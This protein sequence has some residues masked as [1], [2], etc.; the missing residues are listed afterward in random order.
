MFWK[1]FG[2]GVAGNVAGILVMMFVISVMLG[3]ELNPK[4][5][6]GMVILISCIATLFGIGIMW[7]INSYFKVFLLFALAV[8]VWYSFFSYWLC[9]FFLPTFDL[10]Q[11]DERWQNVNS[12]QRFGI[13]IVITGL[14]AG[15]Y[16]KI[17]KIVR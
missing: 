2:T 3:V 14:I 4:Y 11:F 13:S 7:P 17:I 15:I 9:N 6:Q 12:L 16:S 5:I 10:A 8:G 1:G